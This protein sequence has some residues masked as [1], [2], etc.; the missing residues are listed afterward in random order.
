MTEP[1]RYQGIL[2][3][4]N[5]GDS[6]HKTRAGSVL[7]EQPDPSSPVVSRIP[8][9]REVY[10]LSEAEGPQADWSKVRIRQSRRGDSNI[11]A[12]IRRLTN[13]INSL[14]A[15]VDTLQRNKNRVL[16][17]I[18]QDN[19]RIEEQGL[20]SGRIVN[21]VRLKTRQVRQITLQSTR[22]QERLAAQSEQLS[23]LQSQ[24]ESRE[25]QS[26]YVKT[27]RLERL[28]ATPES[29]FQDRDIEQENVELEILTLNGD[30]RDIWESRSSNIPYHWPFNH[31]SRVV[32]N[33]RYTAADPLYTSLRKALIEGATIISRF[34]NKR[35]DR[36]YISSLIDDKF[37]TFQIVEYTATDSLSD[38]QPSISA[39]IEI[40]SAALSLLE[41]IN[42][43][44]SYSE[45]QRPIFYMDKG[46][47]HASYPFSDLIFASYSISGEE[48]EII[49]NTPED[50]G[51]LNYTGEMSPLF[52]DSVDQTISLL[53]N[54]K[55]Q[56]EAGNVEVSNINFSDEIEKLNSARDAINTFIIHEW[57]SSDA[58]T[59]YEDFS[60]FPDNSMMDIL[61]RPSTTGHLAGEIN[62]ILVFEELIHNSL[63]LSQEAIDKINFIASDKTLVLLKS[64]QEITIFLSEEDNNIF[65]FCSSFFPDVTVV[66]MQDPSNLSAR[67]IIDGISEDPNMIERLQGH[68]D[69]LFA[70]SSERRTEYN[71][72][73]SSYQT[74][75]A[76]HRQAI[77]EA[78]SSVDDFF[79]SISDFIEK[80]DE[81]SGSIDQSYG[82]I[83][84]KVD[85]NEIVEEALKCL[86]R[87]A[88]LSFGDL[89]NEYYS[90]LGN[91]PRPDKPFFDLAKTT[92]PS[93]DSFLL[94]D[95]ERRPVND[96]L[97]QFTESLEKTLKELI[98]HTLIETF[99]KVVM[100]ALKNA[101]T[102]SKENPAS[103]SVPNSFLQEGYA[104]SLDSLSG[105]LGSILPATD[106]CS[107]FNGT[108]T[109][110]ALVASL[111]VIE[112]RYP[113][114]HESLRPKN[115]NSVRN[116]FVEMGRFVDLPDC[117]EAFATGVCVDRDAI[118]RNRI[119]TIL[120]SD[121]ITDEQVS[122]YITSENQRR[123][124]IISLLED[125]Q[126]GSIVDDIS[127]RISS[128][129][130]RSILAD[131]TMK[132]SY[133]KTIN[134]MY[135]GL[136]SS[137]DDGVDTFKSLIVT[138]E[139]KAE[140][141]D[142]GKIEIKVNKTCLQGV[143]NSLEDANSFFYNEYTYE[144]GKKYRG[145]SIKTSANPEESLSTIRE[146]L[147]STEDVGASG[148]SLVSSIDFDAISQNSYIE[149]DYIIKDYDL[150]S[151]TIV[152]SNSDESLFSY[153][154]TDT[155]LIR[156]ASG[157]D[158]VTGQTRY[159]PVRNS[160]SYLDSAYKDAI[161]K[162]YSDAKIDIRNLA[163]NTLLSESQ[164]DQ[165]FQKIHDG[166]YPLLV[167]KM[168]EFIS[169]KM[170]KSP[171]FKNIQSEDD[172]QTPVIETLNLYRKCD[173]SSML[174]SQDVNS[175]LS[176][177]M[178][179]AGDNKDKIVD[180]LVSTISKTTVRAYVYDYF[181]RS[182]FTSSMIRDDEKSF[183][184]DSFVN[185]YKTE[186]MRE[187]IEKFQEGSEYIKGLFRT[188]SMSELEI[189]VEEEVKQ[190]LNEI[191]EASKESF[192]FN[193]EIPS[194]TE[195]LAKEFI[196][197]CDIPMTGK[198]ELST[199]F[200][201]TTSY[202]FL[203]KRVMDDESENDSSIFLERLIRV[204]PIRPGD[205]YHSSLPVEIKNYSY[206]NKIGDASSYVMNLKE[207]NKLLNNLH[208]RDKFRKLSLESSDIEVGDT[209][210]YSDGSGCTKVSDYWGVSLER[211][212]KICEIYDE[213]VQ[214]A[215]TLDGFQAFLYG[216]DAPLADAIHDRV[217]SDRI[218]D[219]A[220]TRLF[221][222]STAYGRRIS[223]IRK[224]VKNLCGYTEYSKENQYDAD[225]LF[226]HFFSS[227]DSASGSIGSRSAADIQA[228]I[229]RFCFAKRLG[230][231]E[232]ELEK[233][234]NEKINS[235]SSSGLGL[236][237]DERRRAR[238]YRDEYRNAAYSQC[239]PAESE[240]ED[241]NKPLFKKVEFCYRLCTLANTNDSKVRIKSISSDEPAEFIS[242]D[243]K[244][245][246][247]ESPGPEF[248]TS[249][250]DAEIIKAL[251]EPWMHSYLEK[252]GRERLFGQSPLYTFPGS[253]APFIEIGYSNADRSA[254][255]HLRD[256]FDDDNYDDYDDLFGDNDYKNGPDPLRK[257]YFESP[258]DGFGK[259]F[260][261][262]ITYLSTKDGFFEMLNKI[263]PHD[264]WYEYLLNGPD[265]C[266]AED[267]ISRHQHVKDN[268]LP[269]LD[270]LRENPSL[271]E[272]V[273]EGGFAR[274]LW[275]T[276]RNNK[277]MRKPWLL[278]RKHNVVNQAWGADAHEILY[279]I[280]LYLSIVTD[281]NFEVNDGVVKRTNSIKL[282]VPEGNISGPAALTTGLEEII[283]ASL[284]PAELEYE[285]GDTSYNLDDNQ[286]MFVRASEGNLDYI[287]S[288]RAYQYEEVPESSDLET[289]I[290]SGTAAK[291]VRTLFN[292]K[293]SIPLAEERTLLPSSV[294]TVSE[295]TSQ[296]EEFGDSIENLLL[297]K[298]SENRDFVNFVYKSFPVNE[299]QEMINLLLFYSVGYQS[300][301][302]YAFSSTKFLLKTFY[303]SAST[304]G[305]IKSP[306]IT[307]LGGEDGI[308]KAIKDAT[309][310]DA[311]IENYGDIF[312]NS[313]TFLIKAVAK[314]PIMIVKGLAETADPNI[315]VSKRIKNRTLKEARK[316]IEKA[317]K[318]TQKAID[319]AEITG[320]EVPEIP[321]VPK[322]PDIPLAPISFG[323]SFFIPPTPLTLTYL[324]LDLGDS[325]YEKL[326][327]LMKR[328][329]K[330]SESEEEL[331]TSILEDLEIIDKTSCDS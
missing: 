45:V 91:I 44:V 36:E 172:K 8:A 166:T 119:R 9:N 229:A 84:N 148:A 256:K 186:I 158:P 94:P 80:I 293:Y 50:D 211:A 309:R 34:E 222:G 69:N 248:M 215:E 169:K 155:N 311:D 38:S 255:S 224:V 131:P 83:I 40:K 181:L 331:P 130:D 280:Y 288:E 58:T 136:Y 7:R 188:S 152:V 240:L 55:Q 85:I 93:L 247:V 306:E 316:K 42:T 74:R 322:L 194:L 257:E 86:A 242:I 120:R 134:S 110:E 203:D 105:D 41:D 305:E 269:K 109:D 122:D 287:F 153:S 3:Y 129:A 62:T 163:T 175:G 239:P 245:T 326:E 27:E 283:E 321:E 173:G 82:K 49:L 149:I 23:E 164:K 14:N 178:K 26:G 2:P 327:R 315:K 112:I 292:L 159:S 198:E 146:I 68:L 217:W 108:A 230:R 301:T 95:L 253:P 324:G 124:D 81:Y 147:S 125:V 184:S 216:A 97:S 65:D 191:R 232:E 6:T 254:I 88:G 249:I 273:E 4:P 61:F 274:D 67:D 209:L 59:S 51:A 100:L 142:E 252:Y 106:W 76:R 32:V 212:K 13:S 20:T 243:K 60:E 121:E 250:H 233:Y 264:N 168:Y 25:M 150:G 101:C 48:L 102:E 151:Y 298:L 37:P 73:I 202:H 70:Q 117:S 228:G 282:E 313:G 29:I 182:I 241:L 330:T 63:Q 214:G 266:S 197:K 98:L 135:S 295:F 141:N 227:A 223:S 220:Q 308:T 187:M 16:S 325:A 116:L 128:L 285:Y 196:P 21:R 291:S 201:E 235:Y 139:N 297:D 185:V 79:E 39:L 284:S 236:S 195:L 261:Q 1:S 312:K 24:I 10:V 138:T 127:G 259:F 270:S 167:E 323:L 318:A 170:S 56:V 294:N 33:M 260:A 193:K 115:I 43:E 99:K 258:F 303:D 176:N 300:N 183:I 118:A 221:G 310:S 276:L 104:D 279:R 31:T 192:E 226:E 238:S 126:S 75:R 199:I 304:G 275:N 107:L 5:F 46:P 204:H 19:Q 53:N 154:G 71:A 145:F 205:E 17:Q 244:E 268:V 179:E 219:T 251:N 265:D 30:S 111:R 160:K 267:L 213:E 314:A 234:Y 77:S 96:L 57:N 132:D 262:R 272:Q 157:R 66:D 329:R 90:G 246:T 133:Q 161:S 143:R 47:A 54:F 263:I 103:A 320:I 328:R 89:N 307:R 281:I 28:S 206:L 35:N 15:R 286:L 225:V 114:I 296:Y 231:L 140:R 299:I 180:S 156:R 174:S 190:Q 87:Q 302:S 189:L 12:R 218:D 237:N 277:D 123:Q 18:E 200:G 207:F 92:L 165:V 171:F 317:R 319:Q 290:I 113:T 64:L 289:L 162:S 78:E 11:R 177:K 72:A 278:N 144:D 22:A 52:N 208:P 137:F 210:S 271:I